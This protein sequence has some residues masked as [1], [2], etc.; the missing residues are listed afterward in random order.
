MKRVLWMFAAALLVLPVSDVDANQAGPGAKRGYHG[1]GHGQG[2]GMGMGKGMRMGKRMG[3]GRG[4]MLSMSR[5]LIH[6]ADKLKLT[7]EQIGKLFRL[8]QKHAQARRE[9]KMSAHG[10]MMALHGKILD[11]KSDE[12]AIK[13]SAKQHEDS[14]NKMVAG[15]LQE[16]KEALA[17]LTAEQRKTLNSI[18]LVPGAGD[19]GDQEDEE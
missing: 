19:E 2:Q 9:T 12:A 15:A 3:G 1:A 18:E 7:D 14:F 13:Q 4:G 16:R 17:I 6:N 11:P 8:K 10:S 5:V